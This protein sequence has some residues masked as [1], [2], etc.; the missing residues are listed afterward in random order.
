MYLKF[1]PIFL[2]LACQGPKPNLPNPATSGFRPQLLAI[3]NNEACAIG[4]VNRDGLPDVVAGRM[5]YAAPDFVPHALRSIA[6][7]GSDYAQNNGEHLFDVNED[8][9]LDVVATGWGDPWI[10]WFENPG[11]EGLE[12]GLLWQEHQLANTGITTSEAGFLVDFEDDGQPEYFMNSWKEDVPFSIWQ[13]ETDSAA[14][15]PVQTSIIGPRNGHGVGMGDLNGDGRMDLLM[16]EGW[17][18]QPPENIWAGAWKLHRDWLLKDGSCPMQVVDVNGDGRQDVIWGRG[19]DYG[20]YWLEQGE[21][22][23]DSTTWTEH[24]IDDSW[25][26]VHAL[27]WADLDGDGQGELLTGKR[28]KAHSGHDPGSADPAFLYRYRWNA[29]NGSFDR[30]V[31]AQGNI[32]TGLFI[33]VA[34]LN[35]DERPDVVVA[36]KT[37][38]YILW[39]E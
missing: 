39:Q 21:P 30:S 15:Q 29:A 11:E 31:L 3:D 32:G 26:Q 9:W 37:G 8:G 34:D 10:R 18:E 2:L 13:V 33:R 4:D 7:H 36:G 28:I 12:S 1:L 16:D 23:G 20:L 24:L 38:T 35:Q 17:Y 6:M 14:S 5:W 25:S 19:H 27:S 22:I